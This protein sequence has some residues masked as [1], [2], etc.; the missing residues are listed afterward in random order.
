[1]NRGARTALFLAGAGG[2]AALLWLG[3]AQLPAFG[4]ARHLY[5]NLAVP[6][7]FSRATANVVASVNFDQR[8]LDTMGE[9]TILLGSVT[10]VMALLRPAIEEREYNAP[11][12][13]A[14]LD[15]TRLVGYL[16]LPVTIALGID[17]VV[18]GHLTPGGGFQG[19]VVLAAGL[20]LLYITGSFRALD[21]L[22]PLNVFDIG[23]ALGAAAFV[24]I[25]L[26]GM[27][28]GG[29]FF[30]NLLPTGTMGNLFSSGSV[31]LLNI[32]VGVEV[33]C[34]MTVLLGQFLAQ[35]ITVAKRSDRR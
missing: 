19:G 23:E 13:G 21:R 15:A 10:G 28:V 29:V 24:A 35:E 33:A 1:M 4:Q 8:A 20:H 17:I 6:A 31:V 11:G 27:V 25:G 3:F 18:H 9:E 14:A 12:R 32:A 22:R 30:A 5:R 26:A 7:A 16:M 34:G 2:L